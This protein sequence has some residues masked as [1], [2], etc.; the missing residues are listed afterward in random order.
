MKKLLSAILLSLLAAT[1]LAQV[2]IPPGTSVNITS[3]ATTPSGGTPAF[4]P[5]SSTNN[6]WALW[7]GTGG[8]LLKNSNVTYASPTLSVPASF[9]I[10]GAGSLAFTAGGSNQS[11]TLTPSGT[12][13]TVLSNQGTGTQQSQLSILMAGQPANATPGNGSFY[14][15]GQAESTNNAGVFQ[16]AY[17][18]AG[19][20]SNMLGFGLYGQT[21]SLW[22]TTT[23]HMLLGGLTTDGTGVLQLPAA[24]TAA[25]GITFGTDVNLF[26]AAAQVADLVGATSST[27][28]I[29]GGATILNLLSDGTDGYVTTSGNLFLRTNNGTTAQT[30]DASQ[31]ASFAGTIKSSGFARVTGDVTN[32]T[33]TMS[34]LTNLSVTV[35][36]GTKYVGTIQI[37]ANDSVNTDGLAFDLGGGSCTFTDLEFGFAAQPAGS[38]LGTVTSTTSTTAVTLSIVSTSDA[39]YTLSFGFT[40]NAG[41]TFIPRFAQ[42]SHSTGTATARKNSGIVLHASTN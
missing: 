35:A 8:N 32:A 17:V 23:G 15:F 42:A 26:R 6:A 20:A 36:S 1:A 22:L 24:T 31:N 5:G 2:V 34:N 9:G 21:N 10:T 4:G 28:R 13:R 30:L 16:F 33:A 41:G 7:D 29:R 12:G 25:G 40:C 39:V 38:T 11:I 27:F 19:S 14:S 37:F 18:G 3:A